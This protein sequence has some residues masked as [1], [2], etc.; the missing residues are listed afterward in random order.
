[1]VNQIS[2]QQDKHL[3]VAHCLFD[4][5]VDVFI[6]YPTDRLRYHKFQA[7]MNFWTSRIGKPTR[8]HKSFMLS[9]ILEFSSISV[10]LCSTE[11]A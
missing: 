10:G 1:M 4:E 11:L 9:Q 5:Y 2:E 8:I 6:A 7:T 3:A